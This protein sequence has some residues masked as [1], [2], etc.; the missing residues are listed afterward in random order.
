MSDYLQRDLTPSRRPDARLVLQPPLRLAWAFKGGT[1]AQGTPLVTRTRVV[2]LTGSRHDIAA[3][4]PDGKRVWAYKGQC[5]PAGVVGDD[6]L[7]EVYA[8]EPGQFVRLD[9]AT[10]RTR[11]SVKSE[12]D[13]SIA[14]VF[15]DEEQFLERGAP[16]LVVRLRQAGRGLP[17]LWEHD[18]GTVAGIKSAMRLDRQ[19]ACDSRVCVGMMRSGD[20]ARVFALR[21]DTGAPL[22]SK[23]MDID[24]PPSGNSRWQPVI[25]NGLLVFSTLGGTAAFALKDGKPV[26]FERVGGARTVYGDRIYLQGMGVGAGMPAKIVALDLRTGRTVWRREYPEL[27][28]KGA[29]NRLAGKVGVSETHLFAADEAGWVWAFDKESGEPV[30]Q[31]RPA[32]SS[33]FS[34]WTAP[35]IAGGRLFVASQGRSSSLY[36]FEPTQA[37]PMTMG[38]PQAEPS[39]SGAAFEITGVRRK[40]LI[41][42]RSSF[43]EPGGSWTVMQCRAGGST[44]F[45]AMV[46]SRDKGILASAQGAI[47]VLKSDDRDRLWNHVKAAFG[48][49][50]GKLKT[51]RRVSGPVLL[52]MTVLEESRGWVNTKWSGEDGVPEF[53]VNW[54]L[55]EKRGMI[56]EKD[57]SWR[58]RI[59]ALFASLVVR[60]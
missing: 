16:V 8:R 59:A 37:A 19:F 53:Y 47:W 35:V 21:R 33:G 5:I 54:S 60:P 24:R 17:V 27:F 43:H 4:S 3:L 45:L 20:D 31:H 32:G 58:R 23:P 34:P 40:Q 28:R 50:R 41:A 55:K 25:A 7:T 15:P 30:W 49:G 11:D 57:E 26:W 38:V 2:A 46:E 36:C 56:L 22:W 29:D 48:S 51:G 9:L 18:V 44:F 42:Q 14:A 13:N 39:S 1:V 6:L 12:D 10:G 52:S